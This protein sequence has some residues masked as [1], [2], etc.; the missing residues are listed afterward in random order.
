MA[1]TQLSP[2]IDIKPSTV[3]SYVTNGNAENDTSGW[4]TYADAAQATPVDGTGG[5]PNVTLTRSTSSPLRGTASFLL[6]KD[7]VNR[8]GQGCSYDFT[9]DTA[10][11]AR[12]LQLGFDYNA[13]AAMVVGSSADLSVWIY[14]KTNAI[15]IPVAPYQLQGNGTN[16]FN[17]KGVFQ[18][19]PNST[20]Y[21]L[22]IHIA[23]TNASAWTLKFD[24]VVLAQQILL[25][26][27]PVTDAT[28]FTSTFT[29]LGTISTQN[30]WWWRSGDRMRIKGTINTGTPTAVQASMLLPSGYNVDLSK[31]P[32]GSNNIIAGLWF[33]TTTGGPNNIWP[34]NNAG[35]IIMNA[36]SPTNKLFFAY[37]TSG[38]WV[39]DLGSSIATAGQYFAVDIDLPILGWSSTVLMSNDTDTRVVAARYYS[40]SQSW[41]GALATLNCTTKDFDTHGAYNAGIFTCPVSGIYKVSAATPISA[42]TTATLTNGYAGYLTKNGAFINYLTQYFFTTTGT[43]ATAQFPTGSAIIQCNAGDT[44]QVQIIKDTNA[45]ASTTLASQSTWVA[46]ERLTGPSAIA[47]TETVSARYMN[48]NATAVP[49]G[50]FQYVDFP[51]KNWDS[52][53]AVLGSGGGFQATY[54]N[55]WRFICPVSGIYEVRFHLN[56]A[57]TGAIPVGTQIAAQFDKNGV[58][59][60]VT[61]NFNYGTSSADRFVEWYGIGTVR[62]LA[63]DALSIRIFQNSGVTPALIGTGVYCWAA[64]DRIGNY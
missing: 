51:T 47:A 26:G 6:T 11:Q 20:S 22:I 39:D 24:N 40:S 60:L 46:F 33:V 45:G 3:Q 25:F 5:V 9:I 27:A 7:A 13:S 32:S 57:A 59:E 29:G 1:I 43:V 58:S 53:N 19:N 42:A 54:T 64:I 35:V 55:T 36:G 62:C 12:V 37:K 28:P 34:N 50:A 16:N 56:T 2:D 63:G 44:L 4:A 21:R 18:T 61:E 30:L 41:T 17:Y 8:Q 15:L 31:L 48:A 38:T 23:T 10:D 52:H 49:N 14:D